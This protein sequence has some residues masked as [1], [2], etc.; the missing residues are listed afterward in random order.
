MEATGVGQDSVLQRIVQLVASAQRSRAP[1]QQLADTVAK[2][3][4]PAV[5]ASA[6]VAFLAWSSGT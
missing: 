2:Y 3:F 1:I 6:I 5:I 4:V